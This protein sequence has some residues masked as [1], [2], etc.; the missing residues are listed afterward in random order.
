MNT[1]SFSS[2]FD[3]FHLMFEKLSFVPLSYETVWQI[4]FYTVCEKDLKRF[5]IKIIM[6]HVKYV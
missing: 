6:K 1:S 4:A 5:E 3:I 2:L